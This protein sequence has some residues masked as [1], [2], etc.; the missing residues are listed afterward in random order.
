[1]PRINEKLRVIFMGTPDFSIPSFKELSR[2]SRFD[3]IACVTQPD[4]PVGRK[5]VL[6]N[7]P[8]KTEALRLGLP[9]MQPEKFKDTK[10]K[11]KDLDPDLIIDVAYG[12]IIPDS[13]LIIPKYG[14][15]NVHAGYLPRYRGASPIQAAILN[16]DEKAGVTIMKMDSG[17]DTGPILAQTEL[18]IEP[19][20]T[21]G[22]L[23]NKLAEAGAK[24]LIPT[25]LD[26]IEGKIQPLKQDEKKASYV[27]IIKKEDS[28]I[29]WG[30]EADEIV[31]LIRAMNPWPVAHTKASF[32]KRGQKVEFI[33]K[34][35]ES[36][37]IP[38]DINHY[39]IGEIFQYE[40][41]LAVQCGKKSIL[42][43][44]V[45]LEGKKET[46]SEDFMRGHGDLVG[47]ILH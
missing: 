30:M 41:R 22:T 32:T 11:I 17:L 24:L 23:R 42:I 21:A 15:V 34:I 27:S 44:R 31:K 8:V 37:I 19:D 47:K 35:T 43:K 9:I 46:S 4:K 40:G 18:V 20:D 29:N 1:M 45:I 13:I 16:G 12:Q 10:N 5:Q 3:L 14:C 38:L 28:K 25:L 33:I 39:T 6:T 36:D 7:S 26:Y 2:D